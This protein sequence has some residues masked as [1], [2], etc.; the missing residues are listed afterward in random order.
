MVTTGPAVTRPA[1]RTDG[2]AGAGDTPTPSVIL[3]LRTGLRGGVIQAEPGQD[4]AHDNE[5]LGDPGWQHG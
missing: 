1:R 2:R 5:G 4:A 3:S